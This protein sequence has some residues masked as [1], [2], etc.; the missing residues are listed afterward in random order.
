MHETRLAIRQRAFARLPATNY[1]VDDDTAQYVIS[2]FGL[3]PTRPLVRAFK[4]VATPHLRGK[5]RF[6]LPSG[7]VCPHLLQ[8]ARHG[9]LSCRAVTHKRKRVR[10]YS[11]SKDAIDFFVIRHSHGHQEGA[12]L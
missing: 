8:L 11:L 12:G 5:S 4:V 9:A 6:T 7:I 1:A 3:T 2:H 10:E